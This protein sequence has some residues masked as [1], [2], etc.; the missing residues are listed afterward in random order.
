[1]QTELR[2]WLTKPG[3]LAERL[4]RLRAEAGLTAT[5]LGKAIGRDRTRISKVQTGAA[6]PD[7]DEIRAWAAACGAEATETK[8]LVAMAEEGRSIRLRTWGRVDTYAT[9]GRL[10]ESASCV[11]L[12]APLLFPG[13]LQTLDYALATIRLFEGQRGGGQSDMTD[14]EIAATAASR[15]ARWESPAEGQARRVVAILHQGAARWKVGGQSVLADQVERVAQ[16][17]HRSEVEVG[18]I[19]DSDP[20]VTLPMSP[21]SIYTVDGVDTVIVEDL[22]KPVVHREADVVTVYRRTL[23]YFADLALWG[24]EGVA[25]LRDVIAYSGTAATTASPAHGRDHHRREA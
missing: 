15:I 21:F 3:G 13:P 14:S 8:L 19:P 4:R 23:A 7:P 1:M 22:A 10:H 6:L 25:L 17:V 16:L 18:V 2:D 20:A 12:Y 5:A 24:D 9:T 11:T